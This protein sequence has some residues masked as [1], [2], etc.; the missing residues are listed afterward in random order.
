MTTTDYTQSKIYRI[1]CEDG[2]FYIGSTVLTLRER[3]TQH[4]R[5]SLTVNSRVYRHVRSLGGPDKMKIELVKEN[6]GIETRDELLK[7]EDGFI[8]EGL[9]NRKMCLNRNRP[10]ATQE[11]RIQREI[12]QKR[13]WSSIK[14]SQNKPGESEK[15][16]HER[17]K[18]YYRTHK[19]VRAKTIPKRFANLIV[20]CEE[21]GE[22]CKYRYLRNHKAAKKHEMESIRWQIHKKMLHEAWKTRSA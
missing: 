3:F 2:K 7:I 8:R 5:N 17:I 22:D 21:C 12:L 15:S 13:M 14:R 19:I 18:E 9:K 10:R 16:L 11:E 6:L 20:T 4:C 1:V